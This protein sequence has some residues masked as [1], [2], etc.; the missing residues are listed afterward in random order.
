MR[1]KEWL[2]SIRKPETEQKTARLVFDALLVLLIG[3]ALG[4]FSKWLDQ[5]SINDAVWWQRVLGIL[6][7]RNVF[8]DFSVW[9]LAA[10]AVSVYSKSPL[11]AG[12]HVFLFFA[13]MCASY[14]WYTVAFCG[15]NPRSY[16]MIWYALTLLSP[17]PAVICW[18]GKGQTKISAV[19]DM[20]VLAVMA[21]CC[22]SI[23]FWYFDFRGIPELLIFAGAAAVLHCTPKNTAVSTAGAFVLAFLLGGFL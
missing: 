9:F 3:I 12:L 22:F 4:I 10:L 6:D 15:F 17:F 20:F 7:L 14:H 19:I 5:V 18:Y 2:N 8:S 21:R 13:G 23:G 11:R 16:M 1:M